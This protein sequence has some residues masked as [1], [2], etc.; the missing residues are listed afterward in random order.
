MSKAV[1]SKCGKNNPTLKNHKV[2]CADC[3]NG[4]W[5]IENVED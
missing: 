1:C 2:V 3:G 4:L 5:I